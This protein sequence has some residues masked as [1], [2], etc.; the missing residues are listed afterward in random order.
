ML[1]SLPHEPSASFQFSQN[2]MEMFKSLTLG[3]SDVQ[4]KQKIP[5]LLRQVFRIYPYCYTFHFVET[6]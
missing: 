4:V 2:V 5:Q 3:Q 6:L 1:K